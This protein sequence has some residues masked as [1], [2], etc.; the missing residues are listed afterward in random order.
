MNLEIHSWIYIITNN[1]LDSYLN[2]IKNYIY[3]FWNILLLYYH[4][5]TIIIPIIYNDFIDFFILSSR[6]FFMISVESTESYRMPIRKII[7]ISFTY[8]NILNE[9]TC[10]LIVLDKI[11]KQS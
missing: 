2:N 10:I 3:L 1:Y 6:M 8:V 4:Y 9:K 5:N 7:Y 11:L